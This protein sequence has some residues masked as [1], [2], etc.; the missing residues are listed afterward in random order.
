MKRLSLTILLICALS[1][2][3]NAGVIDIAKGEIIKEKQ[4]SLVNKAKYYLSKK[5]ELLKQIHE[6]DR[7]LDILDSGKDPEETNKITT[8]QRQG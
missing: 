7:K 5:E 8:I 2:V 6:I 4:E 1:T 3:A